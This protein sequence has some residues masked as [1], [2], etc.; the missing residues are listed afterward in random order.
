M[1]KGVWATQVRRATRVA[2]AVLVLL[3]LRSTAVSAQDKVYTPEQLSQLPK[4]ASATDAIAAIEAE[5]PAELKAKHVAGKVQIRFVVNTDGTVDP[6]SVKVVAASDP[7]LGDA[8]SRA[9]KRIRFEP[10]MVN[11]KKV[12]TVVLFPLSFG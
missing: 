2:G 7:R 4:I 3:S 6:K 12:R 11:G 9:V 1:D 8:A 5:Y 10:G